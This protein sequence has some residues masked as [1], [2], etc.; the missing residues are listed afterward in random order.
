MSNSMKYLEK[1]SILSIQCNV[2]I[3][4]TRSKSGDVHGR[5]T[6]IDINLI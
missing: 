5:V 6:I 3:A 2:D 4:L 1:S